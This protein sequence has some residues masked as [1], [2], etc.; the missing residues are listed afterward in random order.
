MLRLFKRIRLVNKLSKISRFNNK[1]LEYI[2]LFW[3]DRSNSLHTWIDMEEEI[4]IL[5]HSSKV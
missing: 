3:T 2:K 1:L 5:K 4:W